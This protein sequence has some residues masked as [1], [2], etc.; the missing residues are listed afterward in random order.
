MVVRF[1]DIPCP[2]ALEIFNYEAGYAGY[3]LTTVCGQKLT[4]GGTVV[5]AYSDTAGAVIT[6]H[7]FPGLA[8]TG[9]G[10]RLTYTIVD[11]D[12]RTSDFHKSYFKTPSVTR[13]S[14]SIK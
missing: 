7:S 6:F 13:Q 11:P 2:D 4:D 9:L 8:K 10:F 1:A 3:H 5:V 12:E 14:V